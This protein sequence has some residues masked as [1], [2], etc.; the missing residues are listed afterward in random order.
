[1]KDFIMT[2]LLAAALVS[3]LNT[4]DYTLHSVHHTVRT[5]QTVW[6]IASDYMEKQ[7]KIRDI[8]ELIWEIRQKNKLTSY[9]IQPGQVLE[10]PL[11]K[12]KKPVVSDRPFAMKKN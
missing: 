8:R 5:G 2:A 9:I 7:D 6:E 4:D 1:M 3:Y 10:I 11:W 12:S